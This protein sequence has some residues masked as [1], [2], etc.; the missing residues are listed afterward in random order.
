M[1]ELRKRFG[2]DLAHGEHLRYTARL[3]GSEVFGQKLWALTKA[4]G[5][6]K[7]QDRQAVGDG[8]P[9]IWNQ[10][11]EH[12]YDAEQTVDWYHAT[13]HYVIEVTCLLPLTTV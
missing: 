8:A 3:G 2:Q 6:E 9:W 10:V 5:W 1:L 4:Y 12:L 11:T 13:E 7:A